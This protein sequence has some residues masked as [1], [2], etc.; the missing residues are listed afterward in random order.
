MS[1]QEEAVALVP[2]V[3]EA[4]GNFDRH[5]V[6]TSQGDLKVKMATANWGSIFPVET[7][8]LNPRTL[9]SAEI[10]GCGFSTFMDDKDI[11]HRIEVI[12]GRMRRA[13]SAR[14]ALAR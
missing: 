5:I 6:T 10:M 13:N 7:H 4:I 14:L 8:Y 2:A 11:E 1:D 9:V 12:I 3:R